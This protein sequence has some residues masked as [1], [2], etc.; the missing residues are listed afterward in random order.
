MAGVI[1]MARTKMLVNAELQPF[2]PAYH[3]KHTGKTKHEWRC[4]TKRRQND[5]DANTNL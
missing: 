3:L 5:G 4:K 1:E 2:S